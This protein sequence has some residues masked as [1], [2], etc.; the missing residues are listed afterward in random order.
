MPLSFTPYLLL[1]AVPYTT[2]QC[3]S[4]DLMVMQWWYLYTSLSRMFVAKFGTMNF[5]IFQLKRLDSGYK[6]SSYVSTLETLQE[7]FL[8]NNEMLFSM[9]FNKYSIWGS[10]MG[11]VKKV[12]KSLNT[13]TSSIIL[14]TTL[15]LYRFGTY[16]E[17][18][19]CFNP[20][21]SFYFYDSQLNNIREHNFM[22][23]NSIWIRTFKKRKQHC[24]HLFVHVLVNSDSNY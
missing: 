3:C 4:C 15:L 19:T 16:Y 12:K 7:S 24:E 14:N 17:S 5:T 20:G 9:Q 21:H 22:G 18:A 6:T 2:M 23:N 11:D 13:K 1:T 10:F 8:C